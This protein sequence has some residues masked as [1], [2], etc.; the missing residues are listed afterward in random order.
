MTP[1]LKHTSIYTSKSGLVLLPND[2]Q[3]E[4][5][6]AP[7]L[8][9]TSFYTKVYWYYYQRSPRCERQDWIYSVAPMPVSSMPPFS[10][11]LIIY[12]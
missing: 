4:N 2:V 11:I 3:V 6:I 7:L 1:L 9:H 12:Q 8:K 10:A 5:P